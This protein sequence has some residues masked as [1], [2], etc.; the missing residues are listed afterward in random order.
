MAEIPLT[1]DPLHDDAYL[2]GVALG[3]PQG[4]TRRWT[5]CRIADR[6]EAAADTIER[7]HA[8]IAEL[9]K[10]LRAV[11]NLAT[12]LDP[13]TEAEARALITK[14]GDSNG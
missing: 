6:V 8:A 4:D 5:L 3:F 7:Q 1:S 14:Y 9:V 2:R 12:V 11:L 10:G 13:F